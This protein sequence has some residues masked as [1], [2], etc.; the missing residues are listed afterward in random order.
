[1]IEQI[2]IKSAASYNDEGSLIDELSKVNIFYGANGSGKTTISRLINDSTEERFK[3]CS[4]KWS[5]DEELETF[6]YNQDFINKNFNQ[7]DQQLKGIFTL[8]EDESTKLILINEQNEA[9][10]TLKTA[11]K[12]LNKQLNG[13]DKSNKGKIAELEHL[14]TKF[15][16]KCWKLKQQYDNTLKEAFTGVR[17][18]KVNFKNKIIYEAENNQ[19]EFLKLEELQKK[20]ETVFSAELKEIAII[21]NIS[22]SSFQTLENDKILQKKIIGKEDVDIADMILRLGNTD[23]VQQGRK[24][25][26]E[27]DNH[28]P[29]CQEK[30]NENFSESLEDYFDETYTFDMDKIQQ[31]AEDYESSSIWLHYCLEKTKD[32]NHKYLDQGKFNSALDLIVTKAN[33]NVHLL[34]QK[35]KE[36]SKAIELE[37]LE[38]D[39]EYINLLINDANIEAQKHNDIVNNHKKVKSELTSQ[40]WH[41]IVDQIKGEYRDYRKEKSL[42]DKAIQSISSQITLK[43]EG[44]VEAKSTRDTLQ[45]EITGTAATVAAINNL[46][47]SLGF[48]NFELAESDKQGFYKIVRSDGSDARKSLS[49]GERTFITFLYFYHLLGG[50]SSEA[51][52][53]SNRVVVIDDPVSSLDS[54]ILF[55]VS[56]LIRRLIKDTKSEKEYIKQ[57]FILTHN[58][59]FHKQVSYRL[60]YKK[61]CKQNELTYWIVRKGNGISKAEKHSKNPIRTSYELLWGE[62]KNKAYTEH[63]VQNILRRILENY[64][65]MF[66]EYEHFEELA[67]K[68]DNEDKF[69]Y[70]SLVSWLHDGSHN[71]LDDISVCAST[72]QIEAQ[73]RVFRLI[74][75]KTDHIAHYKMMMRET[76]DQSDDNLANDNIII[77]A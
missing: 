60:S 39:I 2:E 18:K 51:N 29:F 14:E 11:I 45:R 64:F 24:F 73:L 31:V 59:Y 34:K 30:T 26:Q 4:I 63:T 62:I 50:G 42:L 32:E 1:M 68:F 16:D 33:G 37:T 72:E 13:T 55:I 8:G 15:T 19:S 76:D 5:D 21:D 61:F 49:E 56:T 67:D 20:C 36:A 40:I 66:G 74:F 43:E 58:I 41:F 71:I 75:E 23:W 46:L 65:F 22:F 69:I 38:E 3:D 70:L 35:Q 28:C 10:D 48:K 54:D 17:D 47:S 52:I 27:N 7:D 77:A 44:V 12:N 53:N 6:V 9:I 57:I 25:Y